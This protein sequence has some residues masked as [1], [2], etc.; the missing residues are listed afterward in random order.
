M[1]VWSEM[2]I[3]FEE[4]DAKIADLTTANK[5]LQKKL[6]KLTDQFCRIVYEMSKKDLEAKLKKA[7][8]MVITPDMVAEEEPFE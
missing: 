2:Q 8:E 1:S 4:K 3:E 5:D 7:D 6:D